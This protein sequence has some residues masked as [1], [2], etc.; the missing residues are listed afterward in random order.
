MT[1]D[2]CCGPLFPAKILLPRVLKAS[3]HAADTIAFAS[4]GLAIVIL[5]LSAG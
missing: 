2:K 3:K 4:L 5:V 1:M